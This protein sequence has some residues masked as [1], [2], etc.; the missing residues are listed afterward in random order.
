MGPA[1][2]STPEEGRVPPV[3]RAGEESC[4]AAHIF[5]R[6]ELRRKQTDVVGEGAPEEWD[7]EGQGG[8]CSKW[9]EVNRKGMSPREL[10]GSAGSPPHLT[11]VSE[12]SSRRYCEYRCPSFCT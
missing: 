6:R 2:P 10:P 12:A 1:I 3:R 7:G 4:G 11:W 8:T 9:G 5:Q